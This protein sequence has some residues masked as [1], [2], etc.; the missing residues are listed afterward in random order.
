MNDLTLMGDSP[1]DAIRRTDEH[2]EYWSARDLMP[3]LGYTKW[4]RFEDSV[5]RARISMANAGNDPDRNASRLREPS[6]KTERVNYRLSR[7][8]A[9]VVAMNGDVRKQEIADAQAYFAAKTHE[10]ESRPK[11]TVVVSE[12][13]RRELAAMV[14]AEADRADAAEQRARELE[15]AA[16]SWNTLAEASGDYSLREAAQILDRDPNIR[17]GQNRLSKHLKNIGWTDLSGQPYQRQVEMGRLVVRSRT[18]TDPVTREDRVT[19]QLRV[20]ARGLQVLH[21]EMGGSRP[22]MTVVAS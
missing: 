1:F 17:T 8:G 5:D 16:Q 10:A 12:I 2:G 4:E 3:L 18:Y 20:T 13:S 9:Y 19:T 7:Y 11:T 6:G 21:Q 22:L 14:I 15:P